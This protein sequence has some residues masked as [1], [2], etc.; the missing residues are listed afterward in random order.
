MLLLPHCAAAVRMIVRLLWHRRA[1]AVLLHVLLLW[2]MVWLWL[3]LWLMVPSLLL[4]TYADCAVMV[5][6][7][8][9]VQTLPVAAVAAMMLAL[10]CCL[11]TA[12][13]PGTVTSLPPPRPAGMSGSAM[14]V[15]GGFIRGVLTAGDSMGVSNFGMLI[16]PNWFNFITNSMRNPATGQ[17]VNM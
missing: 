8:Q 16:T 13:W 14:W 17:Y 11:C 3:M 9:V 15:S 2:L 5:Q 6:I 4:A 7:V 1:A 12:T 10:P